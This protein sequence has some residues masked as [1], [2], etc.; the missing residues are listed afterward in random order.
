MRSVGDN[1]KLFFYANNQEPPFIIHANSYRLY[2]KLGTS[3][4]GGYSLGSP[5][6]LYRSLSSRSLRFLDT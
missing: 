2:K 3:C 6:Y 4:S 1:Y 5:D